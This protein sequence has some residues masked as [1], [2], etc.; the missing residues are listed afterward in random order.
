M[1]Y[2]KTTDPTNEHFER[3]YMAALDGV[4]NANAAAQAILN[5]W[6]AYRTARGEPLRDIELHIVHDAQEHGGP[7]DTTPPITYCSKLVS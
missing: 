3:A 6:R 2:D 7:S 1:L 4:D 5:G